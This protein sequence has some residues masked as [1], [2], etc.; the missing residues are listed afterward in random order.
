MKIL[1][2][3]FYNMRKGLTRGEDIQKID[4]RTLQN[5]MKENGNIILLD[6]RSRI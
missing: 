5:L 4:Y 1:Y 3:F 2:K 6:V